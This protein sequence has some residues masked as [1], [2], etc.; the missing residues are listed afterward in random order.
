MKLFVGTS[1]Y[2]Y[3]EWRGHFYP[4]K[5]K[6]ADM[7]EYYGKQL[8]TVEINNTF[9]RMPKEEVLLGWAKKVPAS[10]RF[11]LKASRRITHQLR[12]RDCADPL[13]YLLKTAAVLD[14]KLGALLFQMPPNL[15]LD[16]ERLQEFLDLIPKKTRA[17][18]EFRHLS[19]FDDAVYDELKKRNFALCYSDGEVEGEPFVSTA[20]WGYL[21]LRQESYDE[22]ALKS[23]ADRIKATAWKSVYVY[24]KHEEAGIGARL[25]KKF[26]TFF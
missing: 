23:E 1:G 15:K 7:L 3:K 5:L 24:F 8:S 17:A 22:D 18:F 2:A 4:E 19:W 25:A 12:L 10:F 26:L 21:R 16:L 20:D 11:T 9:Y 14:K 13:A 6:E